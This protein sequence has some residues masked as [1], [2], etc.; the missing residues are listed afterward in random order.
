MADFEVY[1]DLAG[2]TRRV[3]LARSNRTRGSETILFEYDGAWLNDPDR[4]SLEPALALTRGAFAPPAGLAA[5]GSIGDSAPDTWGR[6]LMQRAE[7]R[8]A[9]RDARAVRTL[10]ES[11]YLRGLPTRSGLAHFGSAGS[12]RRSSRLHSDWR[13]GHCRTWSASADHRTHS[14]CRGNR[15]RPPTHFCSRLLARRRTAE[16]LNHRSTWP[17][18]HRKISEGDR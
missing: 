7:R 16:S 11:D 1:V 14:A 12:G 8:N 18:F 5:F 10:T 4:F 6:R 15:R 2:G 13:P 3:G 17:S 9:E